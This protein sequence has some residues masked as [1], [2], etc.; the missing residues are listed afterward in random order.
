MVVIR[1]CLVPCVVTVSPARSPG[2]RDMSTASFSE[3]KSGDGAVP[4]DKKAAFAVRFGESDTHCPAHLA[5]QRFGCVVSVWLLA[6]LC[7][8]VFRSRGLD[9]AE[10]I[11]AANA[12][13]KTAKATLKTVAAN[14]NASKAA[15]DEL[16]H[17]LDTKRSKSKVWF[18]PPPF[19]QCA[20]AVSVV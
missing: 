7:H 8:Q 15:I 10:G 5:L 3:S 11:E 19:T 2:H 20:Q 18:T 14:V 17:A 12:A 13:L 4:R 6:P 9:D 16:Q 1:K